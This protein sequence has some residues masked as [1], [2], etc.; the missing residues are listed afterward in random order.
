MVEL[1]A[2]VLRT[3]LTDPAY[4]SE[5]EVIAESAVAVHMAIAERWSRH[6]D[7]PMELQAFR[8]MNVCWTGLGGLLE[9]R[10][11]TPPEA[12]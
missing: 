10:L 11:R 3:M 9:G 2:G 7:E 4:A 8:A 1:L 12:S 5:I 6:P